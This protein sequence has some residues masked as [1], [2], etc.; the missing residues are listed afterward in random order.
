M[1]NPGKVPMIII[2]VQIGAYLGEDDILRF[3]DLYD[4]VSPRWIDKYINSSG[5]TA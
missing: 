1:E 2:E 4:R 3:E 5:L